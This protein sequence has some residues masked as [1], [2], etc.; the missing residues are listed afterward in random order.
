MCRERLGEEQD[1]CFAT[2]R[3]LEGRGYLG[4]LSATPT[5]MGADCFRGS[6]GSSEK[7]LCRVPLF[8]CLAPMPPLQFPVARFGN[9]GDSKGDFGHDLPVAGSRRWTLQGGPSRKLPK[10]LFQLLGLNGHWTPAKRRAV[11]RSTAAVQRTSMLSDSF[12]CGSTV[13]RVPLLTVAGDE[14]RNARQCGMQ[15]RLRCPDRVCLSN[16]DGGGEVRT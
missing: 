6:M 5:D 13:V 12:L 16:M 14:H 1:L 8:A 3:S 7:T 10:D 2:H 9:L 15:K 11:K 4:M